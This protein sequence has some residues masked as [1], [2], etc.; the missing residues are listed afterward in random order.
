MNSFYILDTIIVSTPIS[1]PM[2][3]KLVMAGPRALTMYLNHVNT[4]GYN[5]VTSC[6]VSPE[7]LAPWSY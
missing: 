5:Q 3:R 7:A 4:A 1:L 2:H 6:I